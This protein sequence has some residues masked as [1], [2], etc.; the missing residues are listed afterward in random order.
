MMTRVNEA[1]EVLGNP[2][3]RA[4]YDTVYF[5]LRAAM[6]EEERKRRESERLDWERRERL[7]QQELGRKRREAEAA[8]RRAAEE[9]RQR[10]AEE[11]RRRAERVR[12]EKERLERERH[13]RQRREAEA[14]RKTEQARARR[15]QERQDHEARQRTYDRTQWS[16]E[17]EV[18]Q[19][20]PKVGRPGHRRSLR[21]LGRVPFWAGIAAGVALS[22]LLALIV[23]GVVVLMLQS[24]DAG[25]QGGTSLVET[26]G[27]GHD[28]G[29]GRRIS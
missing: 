19:T 2:E 15:D 5:R 1:W 3:R 4:E 23:A 27:W 26:A 29:H 22:S 13:E 6:A 9:A 16:R 20:R 28:S 11:E 21:R 24:S 14:R 25:D 7:R 10:A 17:Q 8:R 18:G 12:M